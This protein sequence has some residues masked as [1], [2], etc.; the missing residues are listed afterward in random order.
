MYHVNTE[1]HS[2]KLL[3]HENLIYN[4]H[5]T[6][7]SDRITFESGACHMYV[8]NFSQQLAASKR[9]MQVVTEG[10]EGS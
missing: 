8:T 6:S 9:G 1:K 10:I 3:C 2:S 7:L 4:K 5:T